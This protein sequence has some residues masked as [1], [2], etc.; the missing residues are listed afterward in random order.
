MNN[1]KYRARLEIVNVNSKEPVLFPFIIKASKC[2]GS[3][4]NF[5]DLYARLCVPDI[6]K[7][8]NAKMFNLTSRTNE[9]RRT[10]WHET[11][12]CKCRLDASVSNN[13]QRWNDDK[14]R[15]ECKEL[16]DKGVCNKGFI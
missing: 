3:C 7:N 2:S 16:V 1:Q 13:K 10:E 11:C 14:C 4:N 8:L 9:T 5:N 6:V 15:C 12:K